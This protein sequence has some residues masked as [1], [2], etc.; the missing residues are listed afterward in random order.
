MSNSPYFI[1]FVS[2]ERDQFG[3]PPYEIL[4]FIRS[5]EEDHGPINELFE[6]SESSLRLPGQRATVP[7]NVL[8]AAPKTGSTLLGTLVYLANLYTAC[9]GAQS[10]SCEAHANRATDTENHHVKGWKFFLFQSS[11]LSEVDL[12]AHRAHP[13]FSHGYHYNLDND[14]MST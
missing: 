3:D 12:S 5:G 13:I 1:T 9:H 11:L 4:A 8:M 7:L 14:N 6:G 2:P 10:V